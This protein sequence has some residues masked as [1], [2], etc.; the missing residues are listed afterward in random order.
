M[1][2]KLYCIFDFDG[3]LM[4]SAQY[5]RKAWIIVSIKNGPFDNERD[6]GKIYDSDDIIAGMAGVAKVEKLV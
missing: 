3:T 6:V 2:V 4:D 5:H 1:S